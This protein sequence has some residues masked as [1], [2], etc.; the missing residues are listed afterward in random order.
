MKRRQAEAAQGLKEGVS[1]LEGQLATFV[2]HRP[3][4][5]YEIL[6]GIQ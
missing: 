4:H 2:A 3:A 6:V 1:C 5:T